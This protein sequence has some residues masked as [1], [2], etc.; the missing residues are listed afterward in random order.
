MQSGKGRASAQR[1]PPVRKLAELQRL[2]RRREW[3]GKEPADSLCGAAGKE[4]CRRSARLLA[5]EF[6]QFRLSVDEV[7]EK[8][9]DVLAA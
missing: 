7:R 5:Q 2:F 8:V 6:R 9:I 4:D 3:V 1:L